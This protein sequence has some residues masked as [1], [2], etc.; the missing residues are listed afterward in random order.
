MINLTIKR[1]Y[2]MA[3]FS[4]SP[5]RTVLLAGV[6]RSGT[7]WIGDVLAHV[8]HA[9]ILFEPDLTDANGLLLKGQ[10][11]AGHWHERPSA[12]WQTTL[13]EAH[14]QDVHHMLFG[15]L[16]GGWVNQ[17]A[18]SGIYHR[19]L[20]KSVRSSLYVGHIARTWPEMKILYLVRSPQPVIESMLAKISDGWHFDWSAD[21]I[22]H[23]LDHHPILANR[24]KPAWE[25]VSLIDRLALRYCIETH[26]ALTEL[27]H[28][29]NAMVIRYEQLARQ[30]DWPAVGEF[31]QDQGW[32]QAPAA[33]VLQ[34]PSHTG[35]RLADDSHGLSA[36]QV[37]RLQNCVAAFGLDRWLA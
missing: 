37:A 5:T 21:D 2:Q 14:R 13:F 10:P 29:Q 31:L 12:L 8:L 22:R 4:P 3:E 35:S 28:C 11:I 25:P 19:R 32:D 17:D 23:L 36:S 15:N 27:E 18:K 20:V 33:D 34:R 1:H 30:T 6:G 24:I 9:R 16:H 26:V 7:T